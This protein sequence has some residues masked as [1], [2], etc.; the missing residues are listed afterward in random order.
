MTVPT[1][2]VSC[3]D[4]NGIGLRCFAE[5]VAHSTAIVQY[6]LAISATILQACIDAYGLPG[7]ADDTTWMIGQHQITLEA[8][9]ADGAMLTP[10]QANDG[11]SR[12]AI[13]SLE[14]AIGIVIDGTADAVVTL[15]INKHALQRVGWVFPGQ[16]EMVAAACSGDPL[17]VLCTRDVRVALVTVHVPLRSVSEL[18][19]VDLIV[20]RLHQLRSHLQTDLGIAHPRLAVLALN[21]HAGD[22]GSI[23]NEDDTVVRPAVQ[24][25]REQGIL[26]TGPLPADGFFA[27]GAIADYDGILAMYHDQGLIPLKLLAQ[28]AGVNVTAGI[29]IVRTSP[30]HGT[31]YDRVFSTVDARST[32]VAIDMAVEIAQRRR[33]AM[34]AQQP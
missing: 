28:G 19:T 14:R 32:A 30:D 1:I 31:A 8:V 21:P 10:G 16:T 12:H 9:P 13:S 29:P 25:A 33:S 15:P 22:Q 3:G 5:A 6:R 18:I 2:A 34:T 7:T 17:M 20:Q 27:F 11:I 23:G 24:Q 26:A 4:V